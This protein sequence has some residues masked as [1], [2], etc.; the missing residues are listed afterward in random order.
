MKEVKMYETSDISISAY[1]AMRG[2][3]LL[4]AQKVG[5]K[6]RFI[7]DDQHGLAERYEREYLA[8]DFPRYD[9]SMRQIKR[10][11]YKG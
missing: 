3:T 10:R 1:L 11:L 5:N 2:L 7:F 9:A 4:V 8:S 6:F